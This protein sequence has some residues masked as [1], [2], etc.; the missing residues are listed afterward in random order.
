MAKQ[1]KSRGFSK[2]KMFPNAERVTKPDG[3]RI[4]LYNGKEF[5]TLRDIMDEGEIAKEK[6][7]TKE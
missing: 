4:W 5:V 2:K 1:N 6:A 3:S 7:L